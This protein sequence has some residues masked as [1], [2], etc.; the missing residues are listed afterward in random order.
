[1]DLDENLRERGDRVEF[2]F[3]FRLEAGDPHVLCTVG[4]ANHPARLV[5]R[6]GEILLRAGDQEARCGPLKPD[7]WTTIELTT[8]GDQTTAS[9]DGQPRVSVRH[10]PQATWLYLG[11]GYRTGTIPVGH[12]FL[13]DLPSVRSRVVR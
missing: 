4:D 5:A 12:R 1:V 2:A 11:Q 7:G 9:V 10:T 13:I 3:R 6:S 8:F